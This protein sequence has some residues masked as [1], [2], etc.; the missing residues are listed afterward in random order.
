MQNKES[1]ETKLFIEEI[2]YCLSS[3]GRG[4]IKK[5]KSGVK[6]C[7]QVRE[8]ESDAHFAQGGD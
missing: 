6:S 1:S 5:H 4:N 8:I 2:C 7:N 3:I